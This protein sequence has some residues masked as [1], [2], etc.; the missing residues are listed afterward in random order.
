MNTNNN[1]TIEN[2]KVVKTTNS[3]APGDKKNGSLYIINKEN[4]E[5]TNIANINNIGSFEINYN[6]NILLP[7]KTW[8]HVN[9]LTL[10]RGRW[11]LFGSFYIADNEGEIKNNR[12]TKGN[13]VQDLANKA[14]NKSTKYSALGGGVVT[15]NFSEYI[16][17]KEPEK[18]VHMHAWSNYNDNVE[19]AFLKAIKLG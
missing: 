7:A 12:I 8:V 9:E 10:P 5:P 2:L 6:K 11:L 17:I 13:I 19:Y 4:E 18:E 14:N 3:K 15:H 16:T 1:A